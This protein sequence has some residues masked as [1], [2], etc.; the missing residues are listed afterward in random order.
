MHSIG[1]LH[2][3]F[4]VIYH[5]LLFIKHGCLR[6]PTCNTIYG[7]MK[8]NQPAGGTM[9]VTVNNKAIPGYPNCGSIVIVYN[10]TSGTQVDFHDFIST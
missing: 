6:C 8:G 5:I 1:G 3:V 2:V 4:Y 7:V 9:N 10:F